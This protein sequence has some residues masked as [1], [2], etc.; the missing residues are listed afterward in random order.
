MI[1]TLIKSGDN[2]G[3]IWAHQ[4]FA[5]PKTI[6]AGALELAVSPQVPRE[7]PW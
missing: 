2:T 7:M 1:S 4:F 5:K 3:K 6:A